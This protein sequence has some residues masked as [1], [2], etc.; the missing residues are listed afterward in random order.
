MGGRL[1]N[2][3]PAREKK[4]ALIVVIYLQTKPYSS[5]CQLEKE[6]QQ[7]IFFRYSPGKLSAAVKS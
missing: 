1:S 7:Q 2:T 5:H 6:V 4:E 3:K